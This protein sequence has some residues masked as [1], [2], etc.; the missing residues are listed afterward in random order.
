MGSDPA[1]LFYPGDYLRDTQCLSESAQTAYDR[2]MC[3]HMRNICI[4]Q[5]QLNFF[6][7]RLA[8]DQKS[9]L[10]AVLKKVN[11][12]FQIKWVA[13]SIEKRRNYS[14]SRR[15]NREGKSKH[16]KNTSIS[17]VPHMENEDGN[18]IDNENKLNSVKKDFSLPDVQGEEIHFPIST[19]KVK[20]AWATWKEYRLKE[21]KKIYGMYGEQAALKQL[22]G[23]DENQILSTIWKAI[24]SNWLNLYPN[25]NTSTGKNGNREDQKRSIGKGLEEYYRKK[26]AERGLQFNGMQ[27]S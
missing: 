7:K 12:G 17:Y 21:H 24:E 6:T 5:Q 9:E 19:E 27:N 18:V 13:E 1:F 16:I 2:I 25:G 8:P 20:L 14:D 11:G 26:F 4:S 23:M 3:E 15:K 10:M 22:E